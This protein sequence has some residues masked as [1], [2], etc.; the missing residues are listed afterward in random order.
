MYYVLFLLFPDH[1]DIASSKNTPYTL[2][3]DS[4]E[5]PVSVVD[6]D[7]PVTAIDE[8]LEDFERHDTTSLTQIQPASINGTRENMPTLTDTLSLWIA[9]F[10]FH[11]F[12]QARLYQ[13]NAVT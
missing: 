9:L 1:I 3:T 2:S 11:A 8:V 13:C 12:I 5:V 7:V 10:T 4:N 6:M